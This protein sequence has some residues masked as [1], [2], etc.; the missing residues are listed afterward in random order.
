MTAFNP[1]N[2]SFKVNKAIGNQQGEI[3]MKDLAKCTG[4]GRNFIARSYNQIK[5]LIKTGVLVND[6]QVKKILYTMDDKSIQ[7]ISSKF[8]EV[9]AAPN[10]NDHSDVVKAAH[11]F[12]KSKLAEGRTDNLEAVQELQQKAGRLEIINS[13]VKT[14]EKINPH[15]LLKTIAFEGECHRH[16][17]G[18]K[19]TGIGKDF[20][21]YCNSKGLTSELT[22]RNIVNT[23]KNFIIYI[24]EKGT[25]AFGK[26]DS[27]LFNSLKKYPTDKAVVTFMTLQKADK[28]DELLLHPDHPYYKVQNRDV[29]GLLSMIAKQSIRQNERLEIFKKAEGDLRNPSKITDERFQELITNNVS[30]PMI[31]KIFATAEKSREFRMLVAVADY[32]ASRLEMNKPENGSQKEKLQKE[33]YEKAKTALLLATGKKSLSEAQK[34][35]IK[36]DISLG[37]SSQAFFEQEWGPISQT[38]NELKKVLINNAELQHLEEAKAALN[39]AELQHLEE[40]KAALNDQASLTAPTLLLLIND[41]M[42]LPLIRELCVAAQASPE[43]NFVVAVEEFKRLKTNGN[44]VEAKQKAEE[45]MKKYVGFNASEQANITYE[46]ETKMKEGI[47][48]GQELSIDLFDNAHK[49]IMK[50]FIL[51]GVI[52][53]GSRLEANKAIIENYTLNASKPVLSQ[54]QLLDEGGEDFANL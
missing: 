8:G 28:K 47:Q 42:A 19:G 9:V 34:N 36:S 15:D 3:T 40:A 41:K 25:S 49:E 39:N 11:A 31:K 37:R 20:L 24:Q 16:D 27:A 44:E 26:E 21:T 54:Q 35:V 33:V 7:A 6:A 48:K 5:T 43:L 13:A 2:M 46:Q 45:I 32:N 51:N 22:D 38:R 12:S 17:A 23:Y 53:D 29:S 14:L 18:F 1:E 52:R 4:N 10:L 50:T 30:R